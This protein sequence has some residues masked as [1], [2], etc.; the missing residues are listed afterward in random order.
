MSTS[1]SLADR[2]LEPIISS[3]ELR[4]Q[5]RRGK[6]MARKNWVE[7]LTVRPGLITADVR[8]D[9]GGTNSVR[10]RQSHIDDALWEKV[11][12]RFAGEG[13]FAANLLAGRVTGEMLD[14]FDEVGVD[15]IWYSVR[16]DVSNFCTCREDAQ[17]CTHAVAAHFAL[18]DTFTADP[19]VLFEFRGRSKDQILEALRKRRRAGEGAEGGKEAEGAADSGLE[20]AGE[21][22]EGYWERGVVPHLAF[23]FDA[24]ELAGEETMPVLRALGP[25]PGETS[26]DAFAQVLAP[27]ARL[28]RTR[29]EE[30]LEQLAEDEAPGAPDVTQAE[31]LDDLLYAA[32][33]QHGEL[34]SS[35]VAEALGISQI[36]ARRY[37]QW[38]VEEGRLAVV[39]RARGTK[40][41][42][43]I[44]AEERTSEEL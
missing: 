44:E 35:F 24:K 33:V 39:G 28:A 36:E 4:V 25:G 21:V 29:L 34:T 17:V 10:I 22:V 32:A 43:V 27:I 30:L 38:L 26:P 2:W 37:L 14:V 31:S 20:P 41:V 1:A 16:S 3:S 6:V 19:F 23:R 8:N 12:D 7:N 42:P 5:V 18:A 40:Y 11:L 15:L 13:G 9:I